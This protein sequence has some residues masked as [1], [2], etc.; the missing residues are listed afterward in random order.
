MSNEWWC[1]VADGIALIGS[2]QVADCDPPAGFGARRN[3]GRRKGKTR[4]QIS[5]AGKFAGGGVK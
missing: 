2:W 3:Q 4:P 1:A 5:K